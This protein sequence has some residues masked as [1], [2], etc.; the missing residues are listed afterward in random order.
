MSWGT[1]CGSPQ[2]PVIPKGVYM[3]KVRVEVR[4]KRSGVFRGYLKLIGQKVV[5]DEKPS[6]GTELNADEAD[7]LIARHSR[8]Y[9]EH[10][11]R[12]TDT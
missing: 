7:T 9:G 3:A 4:E 5:T 6:P 10:N 8:A 1:N 11:Y 12:S 2:E